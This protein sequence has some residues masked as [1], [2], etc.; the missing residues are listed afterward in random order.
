MGREA[1][2]V[3]NQKRP[4]KQT[5]R[6]SETLMGEGL[7]N[8]KNWSAPCSLN[9]LRQI[10]GLELPQ[11][12]RGTPAATDVLLREGRTGAPQTLNDIAEAF[13]SSHVGLTNGQVKYL[14]KRSRLRKCPN[15]CVGHL[16]QNGCVL[17]WITQVV[18]NSLQSQTLGPTSTGRPT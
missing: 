10:P 11:H 17:G 18:P 4:T 6:D 1:N 12:L 13:A 14:R 7:S 9:G 16:S 3:L 15:I 2:V 8:E 5:K